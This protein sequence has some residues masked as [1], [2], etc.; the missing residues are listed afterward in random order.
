M[1][2]V[3]IGINSPRYDRRQSKIT[4]DWHNW[5]PYRRHSRSYHCILYMHFTVSQTRADNVHLYTY[6]AHLVCIVVTQPTHNFVYITVDVRTALSRPSRYVTLMS[7]STVLTLHLTVGID[8][9][10]ADHRYKAQGRYGV[11]CR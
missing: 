1:I 11:D 2:L 9:P 5:K 6:T 10:T 4:A 8:R 3:V 7:P